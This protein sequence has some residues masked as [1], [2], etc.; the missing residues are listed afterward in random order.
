MAEGRSLSPGPR[1]GDVVGG[2][3][4][5][6]RQIGQGGM[7]TVFEAQYLALGRSV[8]LKFLQSRVAHDLD[9]VERFMRE[10]RAAAAIAH[11]RIIDVFDVG[12]TDDGLIPYFAMELLSGRNLTWELKETGP[13]AVDRAVGI[14]GQVLDALEAAH[15][16]GI[17]HRDLKPEN[18]FVIRHGLEEDVKVLDFGI[19]KVMTGG[20]SLTHTGAVLGTPAYMSPEQARGLKQIDH[21]T[22]I[23]AAGAILYEMIGGRPPYEGET[24]NEIIVKIATEAPPGIASL[25]PGLH[26]ELVGVIERALARDPETRWPSATAMATALCEVVENLSFVTGLLQ[27]SSEPSFDSTTTSTLKPTPTAW[28]VTRKAEESEGEE[29]DPFDAT[30]QLENPA[31]IEAKLVSSDDGTQALPLAPGSPAVEAHESGPSAASLSQARRP[32]PRIALALALAG[33]VTGAA[34]YT[35][36]RLLGGPRPSNTPEPAGQVVDDAPF[37]TPRPPIAA[38][39]PESS[40]ADR[41]PVV[42]P[43]EAPRPPQVPLAPHCRVRVSIAPPDAS[44]RLDGVRVGTRIDL[45][46]ACG[47]RHQLQVAAPG[48]LSRDLEVEA[49]QDGSVEV[50]L[51][52]A[53]EDR[54]RSR[55]KKARRPTKL[56]PN[57]F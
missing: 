43:S 3:Y 44:V 52:P 23:Y 20:G 7:G 39:S 16:N 40:L 29:V 46:S 50:A 27:D 10:A 14:V 25:R 22:D 30:R 34:T 9:L 57:P 37:G 32:R 15:S 2:K 42:A 55:I 49:T 38:S 48:H 24:Y 26:P 18:V 33:L 11:P 28:E 53:P 6:V 45:P 51:D 12:W 5:L 1:V 4:R 56:E 21:R 41:A 36:G 13:M 54:P 31:G 17:V 8:A 19:S 35:V 47:S